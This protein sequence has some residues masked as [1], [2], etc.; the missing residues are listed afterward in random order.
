MK[1]IIVTLNKIFVRNLEG[2]DLMEIFFVTAVA[3][4]LPPG[5]WL[6][7]WADLALELS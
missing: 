5:P 7:S 4:I 6:L 3:S 2:S 1:N